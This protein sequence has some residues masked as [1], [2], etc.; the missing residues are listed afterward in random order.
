MNYILNSF[1]QTI[2][3][4]ILTV[5]L[6]IM[7]K[8]HILCPVVPQYQCFGTAHCQIDFSLM[9]LSLLLSQGLFVKRENQHLSGLSF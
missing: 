7:A 3:P 1:I 6:Q 8:R 9:V 4:S 2:F 5:L